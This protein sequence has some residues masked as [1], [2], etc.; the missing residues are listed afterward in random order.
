MSDLITTLHPQDDNSV[1]LYPNVKLENIIDGTAED[2]GKFVK[3]NEEGKFIVE[4][5]DI[6]EPQ[7][8]NNS[9]IT[10]K[11]GGVDKGSFSLNQAEDATIELDAGGA[12]ESGSNMYATSSAISK[13]IPAHTEAANPIQVG[14]T[15]SQLYF[16]TQQDI[17]DYLADVVDW[18]NGNKVIYVD[19][20]SVYPL[21]TAK[22]GRASCRERV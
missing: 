10:I 14:D 22:I 8:V 4:T 13:S 20:M 12:G 21:L 18:G 2:A 11:Q 7:Q 16:N 1:N 19:G 6:P 15:I 3:V 17:G 9:T 5:V